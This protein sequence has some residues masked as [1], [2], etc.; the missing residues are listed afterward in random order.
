MYDH[1]PWVWRPLL[2]NG[3]IL[4]IIVAVNL[5]GGCQMRRVAAYE[6]GILSQPKM[7]MPPKPVDAFLDDHIYFSKEAS[8]GGAGGG[9]GGC[10]CN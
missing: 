9:G 5:L 1:Q 2:M 3:F 6:R 10:G 7:Q 8:R 4:A